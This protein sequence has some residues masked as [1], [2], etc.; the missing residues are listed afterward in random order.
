[1]HAIIYF[2]KCYTAENRIQQNL[3][4]T[5][6]YNEEQLLKYRSIAEKQKKEFQHQ[7]D[8]LMLS[9]QVYKLIVHY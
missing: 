2:S 7:L 6:K 4:R 3:K 9:N 1:M 8:T 5:E